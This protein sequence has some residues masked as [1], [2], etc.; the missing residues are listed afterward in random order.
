ML[1]DLTKIDQRFGQ[2]LLQIVQPLAIADD[3]Q[4][5]LD[6]LAKSIAEHFK[7]DG[8]W[9]LHYPA[10]NF[11]QVV[12]QYTNGYRF[13]SIAAELVKNTPPSSDSPLLWRSSLL[14]DYQMMV[15][16]TYYQQHVDGCIVVA[17]KKTNW[18]KENKLLLQLAADYTAVAVAHN[19]FQQQAEFA[20]LYPH[21]QLRLTQ[22]ISER[23]DLDR[24]FGMVLED[25]LTGLKLDRGIVVG[26]KAQPG[27]THNKQLKDVNVKVFAVA[28]RHP[29]AEEETSEKPPHPRSFKLQDSYLCDRAR[30]AAP[31]VAMLE[32]NRLCTKL[33]VELLR[34]KEFPHL[35]FI[36][37][38]TQTDILWGWLILQHRHPRRWHPVEFE[39]IRCPIYQIAL[40]KKQRS[41]LKKA[42]DLAAS[43]SYQIETSLN[44][45]SKLHDAS[46]RQME[47]LR[48][49]NDLKDE[50][51]NTV[52]H[53]LL[54]PLTSMKMA[55]SMLKNPDIEPERRERYVSILDEQ[56]QRE[57]DLIRNL[58]TLQQLESD[59]YQIDAQSIEL[60]GTMKRF[61]ADYH[62][63]HPPTRGVCFNL[64]LPAD[65]I[66]VLTQSESLQSIVNELLGNAHKFALPHTGIDFVVQTLGKNRITITVSNLSKPISDDDLPYIFEKFRRATGVT[67]NAIAGTGLGLALVKSLVEHIQGEIEVTCDPT[68][69]IVI[70]QAESPALISF[71]VI[72]PL[73]LDLG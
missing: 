36:P 4:E 29:S 2:R 15:V 25:I 10:S 35:T 65:E 54:T 56:C 67:Q 33:D 52:S 39:L 66:T 8:C 64:H 72:L 44:L 71:R 13:E 70:G 19:Q 6:N 26:W 31:S 48:R 34:S 62:R 21:I 16:D 69:E 27:G 38:L 14:P 23:Q 30:R 9:I 51:I 49:N 58:L 43:R 68:S 22:A 46:R 12:A 73:E 7:A 20:K 28:E 60:V 32:Y 41:S 1:Q 61:C 59:L 5:V 55:I 24:L 11:N 50:F 42:E 57:I 47:K 3:R 37:L 53:E 63:E 18:T 17:S 40:A 45:Q